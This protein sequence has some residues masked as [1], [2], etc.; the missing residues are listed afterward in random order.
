MDVKYHCIVSSV[1]FVTALAS[2][3]SIWTSFPTIF[4]MLTIIYG[5]GMFIDLDHAV[6]FMLVYPE[7]WNSVPARQRLPYTYNWIMNNKKEA[8][9]NVS[10]KIFFHTPFGN[11][12]YLVLIGV[13]SYFIS[14]LFLW[15]GAAYCIH[16]MMDVAN[17]KA[18]A[19]SS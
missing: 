2:N 4:G 11:T 18:L 6:A 14:P 12:I 9:R 15:G 19:S 7:K 10:T 17:W 16:I 8:F 5:S 1:L 3:Q 13:A